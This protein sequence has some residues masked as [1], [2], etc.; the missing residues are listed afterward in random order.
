MDEETKPLRRLCRRS[1][2]G[3]S[4]AANPG[5]LTPGSSRFTN[6]NGA[7]QAMEN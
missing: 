1:L 3:S 7:S 2:Q 4:R 5:V 6:P